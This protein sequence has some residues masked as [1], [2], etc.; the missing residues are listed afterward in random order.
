MLSRPEISYS[1]L[2]EEYK[3]KRFGTL[4][5]YTKY[6]S[7]NK[8]H[9]LKTALKGYQVERIGDTSQYMC[10]DQYGNYSLFNVEK[11]LDYK[12]F[13]D[14]YTIEQEKAVKAY[15]EYNDRK[16]IAYNVNK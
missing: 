16:K 5:N 1:Y 8:V 10:K 12:V 6:I 3:N 13:L 14:I 7:E 2:D 4:E 9:I 15:N 11:V